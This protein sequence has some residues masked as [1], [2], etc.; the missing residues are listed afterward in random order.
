MKK[1]LV[2]F[3]LS[4]MIAH[5]QY[6]IHY[7]S[8]NSQQTLGP[9][10]KDLAYLLGLSTGAG[11]TVSWDSANASTGILLDIDPTLVGYRAHQGL[12]AGNGIN[13]LK[14][15][16]TTSDGVR[17]ALY[18]WLQTQG[19][20]F[21][22]PDSLYQVIPTMATPFVNI[23]QM[24]TTQYAYRGWFGSGY[25]PP[26]QLD[27]N[28][29]LIADWNLYQAR[30][31]MSNEYGFGGHNET[32]YQAD[33]AFLVNNPCYIA[34]RDSSRQLLVN[35]VPDVNV[36]DAMYHWARYLFALD[37]A[38]S[39]AY[40]LSPNNYFLK[41]IETPDGSRWGNTSVITT[42]EPGASSGTYPSASTQAFTLANYVTDYYQSQYSYPFRTIMYA[43]GE[44]AD[45]PAV[46]INPL[47]DVMVVGAFGGINSLVELANR[48]KLKHP[49]TF[50]YDYINLPD[51]T[52]QMPFLSTR[53]YAATHNRLRVNQS[54]G[55]FYESTFSKFA[56]I[57]YLYAFQ[58]YMEDETPIP[59]SLDNYFVDMYGPAHNKVQELFEAWSNPYRLTSGNY[60]ADNQHRLPL[61]LKLINEA[62]NLVSDPLIKHRINDLKAY[63]HYMVLSFQ[64]EFY[65]PDSVSAVT[66]K[67]ATCDF[68]LQT[69]HRKIAN[70]YQQINVN[71]SKPPYSSTLVPI[72]FSGVYITTPH[73]NQP[74]LTDAEI[75]NLFAQDLIDYPMF[76]NYYFYEP[77]DAMANFDDLN[78]QPKQVIHQQQPEFLSAVYA[79]YQVY[80]PHPGSVVLNYKIL[81]DSSFSNTPILV[82]LENEDQLYSHA[83]E[84]Y[85]SG[86]DTGQIELIVPHAGNYRLLQTTPPRMRVNYHIGTNQNVFYK[87]DGITGQFGNIYN[88]VASASRYYYVPAGTDKIWLTVSNAC[89]TTCLDTGMLKLGYKFFDADSIEPTVNYSGFDSTL[90]YMDVPPGMDNQFW[91]VY[92]QSILGYSLTFAN[93]SNIYFHLERGNNWHI[94]V[95]E[96]ESLHTLVYPVPADSY[97]EIKTTTEG[98]KNYQ[99]YDLQGRL[100]DAWSLSGSSCTR[101]VE[102]L[103]SGI[104]FLKITSPSQSITKKFIIKHSL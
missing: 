58:R 40:N 50:E 77:L 57:P 23:H 73:W 71:V 99:I 102:Q 56:S 34:E 47:L 83:I 53:Y 93:I 12:V 63:A 97:I 24:Y 85:Y 7:D 9:E 96:N 69:A 43:Y 31:N 2:M 61:Y 55:I 8:L 21:Y 66:S 76:T 6:T 32:W 49:H 10:A 17:Y 89:G 20:K 33:S 46:A 48:W 62:D 81:Y 100:A 45:T 84:I 18:R 92:D 15:S 25:L 1:F 52:M 95:A 67:I 88:D 78:Y 5:A 36:P 27:T 39:A 28:S 68:L 80:A 51:Q 70:Y 82:T 74:Q 91:H 16:S 86:G 4:G 104:Y 11:Y 38:Y 19:F 75:D 65:W 64:S 54:R 35:S 22:A 14:I 42:C 59:T 37:S 87:Q 98:E 29:Q 94:S 44:A 90:F 26:S 30:N 41:G 3:F 103:A 60:L 79:G 72:Y 101:R 13:Q